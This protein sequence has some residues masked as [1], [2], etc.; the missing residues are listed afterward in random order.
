MVFTLRYN[1]KGSVASLRA[2]PTPCSCGCY[3]SLEK[4]KQPNLYCP[5]VSFI[6]R[7][8]SQW[9]TSVQH[10]CISWWLLVSYTLQHTLIIILMHVHEYCTKQIVSIYCMKQIVSINHAVTIVYCVT[11]SFE[12][13]SYGTLS[14]SLPRTGPCM[15]EQS[16]RDQFAMS[17]LVKWNVQLCHKFT[18]EKRDIIL[19]L[20]VELAGKWDWQCPAH[21]SMYM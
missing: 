2:M 5:N 18:S 20:D 12:M 15:H 21:A 9:L 3:R 8:H 14:T 13:S 4:T 19:L 17:Y 11:Q 10:D 16:V 6:R 7:F 1:I